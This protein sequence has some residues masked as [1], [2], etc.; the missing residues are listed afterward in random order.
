MNPE[1]LLHV[2]RVVCKNFGRF[3]PYRGDK[4]KNKVLTSEKGNISAFSIG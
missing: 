1:L 4:A 3:A 2:F